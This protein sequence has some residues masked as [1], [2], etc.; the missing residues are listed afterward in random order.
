MAFHPRLHDIDLRREHH[1]QQQRRLAAL[2][3]RRQVGNL[4][5]DP[6]LEAQRNAAVTRNRGR[7]LERGVRTLERHKANRV[8]PQP[9]EAAAIHCGTRRARPTCAAATAP[10]L[11]PR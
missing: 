11:A 6:R 3:K 7:P 1:H 8:P 10:T 9:P 2:P 4:P 5:L